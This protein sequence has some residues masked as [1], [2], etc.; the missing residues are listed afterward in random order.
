MYTL[1]ISVKQG[2]MKLREEFYKNSLVKDPRVMDLLVMKVN[3]TDITIT[4]NW[5]CI[6]VY[7]QYSK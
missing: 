5:M 7:H 2:R 3:Y 1:D 4:A 6:T